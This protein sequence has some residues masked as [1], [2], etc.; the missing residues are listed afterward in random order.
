MA[1]SFRPPSA[2]K[3]K[4]ASPAAAESAAPSQAAPDNSLMV[5]LLKEAA[6]QA[7]VGEQ[8]VLALHDGP[9]QG[10]YDFAEDGGKYDFAEDGDDQERVQQK[11]EL[12]KLREKHADKSYADVTD[13][14]AF[15]KGA[16][17]DHAIDP[18]DVAQGALGDC[19]LMAGMIAVARANPEA[20]SEL[21]VDNGDGTFDVTLYIRE[22]RWGDPKKVT[23]TIDARLPMK[24]GDSPLYAKKGDEGEGETELWAAL[25]EKT[26]AQHKGSYDLI[27]GGN[28][29]TDFEFHGAT[30]LLTGRNEGYMRT[31]GLDEDEALLHIIFA[32]EDKKPVTC[33][34]KNMEDDQE[35]ADEARKHN[36]YGNHAYCPENVDLD[37]RTIDLTNPWGT[38]HVTGLDVADFLR[39]Y[40]SIRIGA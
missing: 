19:Y 15:V 34:S 28:I 1:K 20:I 27:S 29:S 2:D 31:S 40:R 30:E 24:H 14:K 5:D 9:V 38:R 7:G 25:I 35:L 39:F 6:A 10:K 22:S 13:A 32:L 3:K 4:G 26:V 11:E 17:D 23:K 18:N 16:G 21:I 8:T 12:P 36:V 33:D 37:A